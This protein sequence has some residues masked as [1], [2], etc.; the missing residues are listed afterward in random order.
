M[1]MIDGLSSAQG[2][3][4]FRVSQGKD[5]SK[6]AISLSLAETEGET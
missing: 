5:F 2:T 1:K 6:F 4:N 3:E